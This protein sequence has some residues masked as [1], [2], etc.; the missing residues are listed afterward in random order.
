MVLSHSFGQVSGMRCPYMLARNVTVFTKRTTK[1][2]GAGLLSHSPSEGGAV[3]SKVSTSKPS[4]S[5][6]FPCRPLCSRS[7]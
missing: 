6:S 3:G 4:S 2:A 5:R 7:R 1:W